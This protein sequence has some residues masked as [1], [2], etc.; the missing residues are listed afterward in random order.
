MLL[1]A[2][3]SRRRCWW[4]EIVC[5]LF[6][7]IITSAIPATI[8]ITVKHRSHDM[9]YLGYG[10]DTIEL[11]TVDGFWYEYLTVSQVV[12]PNDH[13][14][15]IQLYLPPCSDI[16]VH[17][18]K[19]HYVS[20][21]RQHTYPTRL[22]ATLDY[23]YLLPNSRVTYSFCMMAN[24]TQSQS[25][26]KFFVFNKQEKYVDYI[27][28]VK[29][30]KKL[31]ISQYQMFIGTPSE[32]I[33]TEFT[34]TAKKSDYYFFTGSCDAGITYQYNISTRTKY[35]HFK[36]YK[37]N[38]SCSA[39]TEHN[40]CEIPVGTAFLS[41]SEKYC[42]LAHVIPHKEHK[43]LSPTTHIR[44]N[45]GKR[46]KVVVIPILVIVVSIMGLLVV[47]VTYCCCCCK[48]CCLQ[49]PR[50]GYTLINV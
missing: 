17:E 9:T 45:A 8:I 30:G 24:E 41:K 33:C 23:Y 28:G 16:D 7:I 50:R 29:D 31:S 14:H 10:G 36:D 37:E 19:E 42:L 18:R 34:F 4:R 22:M 35:L 40:S 12:K 38:K 6:W 2:E 39:L 49:R 11:L 43:Q 48:K 3:P 32:P 20:S 5:V 13:E 27:S 25:P 15:R 1:Q 26:A 44:V 47:V 46:G 21:Y